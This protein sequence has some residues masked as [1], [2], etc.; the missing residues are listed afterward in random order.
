MARSHYIY[1]VW[2]GD[3]KFP[4]HFVRS[5]PVA[6]FTVKHELISWLEKCTDPYKE[7]FKVYRI[8]DNDILKNEAEYIEMDSTKIK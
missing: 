5:H 7:E 6:A 3:R 4:R 8:V 1:L 2:R